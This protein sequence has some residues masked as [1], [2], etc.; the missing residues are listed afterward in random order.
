M[1]RFNSIAIGFF[2][3]ILALNCVGQ[4]SPQ[5]FQSDQTENSF[6]TEDAKSRMDAFM[7]E[8]QQRPGAIGYVIANADRS[9]PGRFQK[10]FKNFQWHIGYRRFDTDRIKFYRAPDGGSMRFDYW[11]SID[12]ISKP[13][14]PPPYRSAAIVEPT[15]YDSSAIISITKDGVEFGFGFETVEP[16]DWGLNL[17][18]FAMVLNSDP[19][20]QAYLIASAANRT[21]ANFVRRALRLTSTTLSL[22]HG[23]P[24]RRIETIFAGIRKGDE[25]QLWLVPKGNKPPSFRGNSLP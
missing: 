9:I 8:L 16:C 22:E 15:L 4:D 14:L 7:I 13:E 25:M 18:D 21:R 23:I 11:I 3:I 2:V 1:K 12:G 24:A 6:C 19:N 20:L 10:Y 5:F 17:F